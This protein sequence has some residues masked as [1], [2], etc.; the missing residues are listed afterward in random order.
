MHTIIIIADYNKVLDEMP[1]IWYQNI[2]FTVNLP[3]QF[4]ELYH[5]YN[6]KMN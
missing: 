1:Q 6:K 2:T 4:K 5:S 3:P